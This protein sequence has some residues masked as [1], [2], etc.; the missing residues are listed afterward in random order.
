MTSLWNSTRC[1]KMKI[2]KLF[3]KIDEEGILL[4]IFSEASITLT[5]KP[6]KDITRRPQTN[7]RYEFKYKNLQQNTSKLNPAT[8]LKYY[9]P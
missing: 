5:L 8:Y 7:I 2:C 4:I 3:Q 9:T 6:H 1:L